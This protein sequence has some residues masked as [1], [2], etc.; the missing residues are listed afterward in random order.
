MQDVANALCRNFGSVFQSQILWLESLDAL[1]AA[2]LGI[3][4]QTPSD[5]RKIHGDDD[6]A[7]A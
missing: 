6:P 2:N 1:L 5:L 4:L 3:P 7:W